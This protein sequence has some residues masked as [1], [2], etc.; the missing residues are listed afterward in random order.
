MASLCVCDQIKL[1]APIYTSED[2]K[3]NMLQQLLKLRDRG[4]FADIKFNMEGQRRQLKLH[5]LVLASAG[6]G[7][8]D[9]L[10]S[11]NYSALAELLQPLDRPT[12]DAFISFV[13][14]G[15][16][17]LGE[18]CD[19]AVLME[20]FR[21][22]GIKEGA[23][24]CKEHLSKPHQLDP[25]NW[26]K[27]RGLT[28]NYNRVS[29]SNQTWVSHV[30]RHTLID[31]CDPFFTHKWG[32]KVKC[33]SK[34]KDTDQAHKVQK[35]MDVLFPQRVQESELQR[36]ISMV[37]TGYTPSRIIKT[38]LLER[39]ENEALGI[40]N[41]LEEIWPDP[42]HSPPKPPK[43]KAAIAVTKKNAKTFKM[44]P[45]SEVSGSKDQSPGVP[46]LPS[47]IK[48]V[49]LIPTTAPAVKLSTAS[50]VKPTPAPGVKP[51]PAPAGK[52]PISQ[53]STEAG[54]VLCINA[55]GELFMSQPKNVTNKA[56]IVNVKETEGQSQGTST[57]SPA[58]HV[59]NVNTQPSSAQMKPSNQDSKQPVPNTK[60]DNTNKTI[61]ILNRPIQPGKTKAGQTLHV[62][63]EAFS[64]KVK[65]ASNK[66]SASSDKTP[67]LHDDPGAISVK[68]RSVSNRHMASDDQAKTGCA[69]LEATCTDLEEGSIQ[70]PSVTPPSPAALTQTLSTTA[71]C[72]SVLSRSPSG[73]A[74]SSHGSSPSAHTAPQT[75]RGPTS[76]GGTASGEDHEGGEPTV[77]V[78]TGKDQ[79]QLPVFLLGDPVTRP[80]AP[81][82]ATT[83]TGSSST[84]A[85]KTIFG[86]PI[87]AATSVCGGERGKVSGGPPVLLNLPPV[88]TLPVLPTPPIP[89]VRSAIHPPLPNHTSVTIL[90]NGQMFKLHSSTFLGGQASMEAQ[91]PLNVLGAKALAKPAAPS[92]AKSIG[93]TSGAKPADSGQVKMVSMVTRGL[94]SILGDGDHTPASKAPEPVCGTG[95]V[96]TSVAEGSPQSTASLTATQP[97]TSG[98]PSGKL[99]ATVSKAK[100]M[101]SYKASDYVGPDGKVEA[102]THFTIR[103]R[104]KGVLKKEAVGVKRSPGR[105]C[106]SQKEKV[107]PGDKQEVTEASSR[108]RPGRKPAKEEA[109][110]TAG[111]PLRKPT[112][113]ESQEE[114]C[115]VASKR[116]RLVAALAGQAMEARPEAADGGTNRRLRS[117]IS[118]TGEEKVAGPATVDDKKTSRMRQ[119]TE[120]WK[121]IQERHR[122][123]TKRQAQKHKVKSQRLKHIK[124]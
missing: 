49:P 5:S 52:A 2:Y 12:L 89:L 27:D 26:A 13:Y 46:G 83:S 44:K 58:H 112:P 24:V 18:G 6:A 97:S 98:I 17:E 62:N 87:E 29:S 3:D 88:L 93:E 101:K 77:T 84:S 109:R 54:K 47:W 118:T 19:A 28:A 45:L 33:K 61:L 81:T 66:G 121:V 103:L 63:P 23:Q 82:A 120:S 20:A 57:S 42:L 60:A 31:N 14:S 7:L 70:P 36:I 74:P 95:P 76:V 100:L 51:I 43:I 55:K 91:R 78:E 56:Q 40:V 50:P 116:P 111:H 39:V 8:R 106:G 37:D 114:A 92:V 64:G 48:T 73:S 107:K 10:L 68:V 104:S 21:Q 59:L 1:R 113:S 80:K 65:A 35:V 72:P 110:P 75:P 115:P 25:D 96:S 30:H 108:R 69:D 38:L 15:Q 94:S 85:P 41:D 16:V 99:P 53:A 22:A 102:E 122:A 117:D 105:P 71:Q 123:S 9:H 86:N 34:A 90:A 4:T 124:T 11:Q 119:L 79:S 32:R 67:S